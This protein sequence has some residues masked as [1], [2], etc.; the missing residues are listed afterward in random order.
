KEYPRLAERRELVGGEVD[1]V[2]DK[3]APRHRAVQI[4]GEPVAHERGTRGVELPAELRKP[5]GFRHAEPENSLAEVG[6]REGDDAPRRLRQDAVGWS[7]QRDEHLGL[8]RLALA[9]L[10]GDL[11]EKDA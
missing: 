11:D 4:G 7:G 8:V 9:F 10:L 3:L 5:V 6:Q 2:D 1:I